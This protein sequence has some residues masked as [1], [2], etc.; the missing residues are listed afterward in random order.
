MAARERGAR[1]RWKLRLWEGGL[2]AEE[3][4]V[5]EG[6]VAAEGESGWRREIR[7]EG[8]ERRR[9]RMKVIPLTEAV[10]E[11]G[12]QLKGTIDGLRESKKAADLSVNLVAGESSPMRIKKVFGQDKKI[13][14]PLTPRDNNLFLAMTW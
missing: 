10:S 6:G 3:G 8:F 7:S 9:E 12:P 14:H 4:L 13:T 1:E 11:G 5:T 2:S